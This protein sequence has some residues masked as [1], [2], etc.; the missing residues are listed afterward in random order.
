MIPLT[1]YYRFRSV[2]KI[3]MYGYL[4]TSNFNASNSTNNLLKFNDDDGGS[5]QFLILVE[6]NVG[7]YTLVATTYFAN[8]TGNFSILI[9]GP[10]DVILY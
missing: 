4:Y 8:V 7:N 5:S 3:D 2:S 1:N 6:L 9:D 10:T